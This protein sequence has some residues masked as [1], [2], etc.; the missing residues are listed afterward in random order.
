LVSALLRIIARRLV[1]AFMVIGLGPYFLIVAIRPIVNSQ[2]LPF[3]MPLH[4]VLGG[5]LFGGRR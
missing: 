5:V 4:G 2:I 1:L 3:D